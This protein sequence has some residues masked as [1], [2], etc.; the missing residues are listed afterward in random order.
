MSVREIPDELEPVVAMA[1]LNLATAGSRLV[2]D[3]GL[4][5]TGLVLHRRE[6]ITAKYDV[7][8][9]CQAVERR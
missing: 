2:S 4:D 1:L 5:L 3:Q 8:L 7:W 9:A 6:E